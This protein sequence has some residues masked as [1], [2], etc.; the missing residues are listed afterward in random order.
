MEDFRK[1]GISVADTSEIN[2]EEY[3]EYFGAKNITE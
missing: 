3:T 2:M 1:Y